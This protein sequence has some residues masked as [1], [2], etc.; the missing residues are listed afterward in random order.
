MR[1]IWLIHSE[2][3]WHDF[4]VVFTR[5]ELSR[6]QTDLVY[7]WLNFCLVTGTAV[8]RTNSSH[9]GKTQ[10]EGQIACDLS[11]ESKLVSGSL[12]S[13]EAQGVFLRRESAEK[14]SGGVKVGG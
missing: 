2:Q 14:V 9:E 4:P 13:A 12:S 11:Y 10:I 8:S 1:E 3:H 6:G 7:D 5:G